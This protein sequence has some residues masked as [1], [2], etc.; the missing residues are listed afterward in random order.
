VATIAGQPA[1]GTLKMN[2]LKYRIAITIFILEAMM[3]SIV[4]WYTL[5]YAVEKSKQHITVSEQVTMELVDE[6]ARTALLTEEYDIIQPYIEKLPRNPDILHAILVD[7]SNVIVASDRFSELGN[8]LPLLPNTDDTHWRTKTIKNPAGSLGKLA[9]EFSSNPLSQAYNQAKTLGV[10][11]AIIGMSIIAMVGTTFGTVLTKRLKKLDYAVEEVGK[12]NF[13]VSTGIKGRDELGRLGEAF[14]TMAKQIERDNKQM[15]DMNKELEKRVE[16]RTKALADANS[17]YES[18]AYSVSH[19]LRAPLR[20]INGFSQALKDDYYDLLDD[21]AKDYL[22]RIQNASVRMGDL[23]DALLE[24]SRI[25]R[26]KIDVKQVNLSKFA[27][28]II[29][30][31]SKDPN[32]RPVNWQI[33]PNVKAYGDSRLLY[34]VLSNLLNNAWKFTQKEPN[35]TIEFGL[36]KLNGEDL[37]YV[38]DNG[39]G[40]NEDYKEKLFAP[41]NRLHRDSEFEGSGIGLS[42]VQRI[43]HRHGGRIWGE[44]KTGEGATFYF[45]LPTRTPTQSHAA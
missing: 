32:C 38:K 6:I 31:L 30:E 26:A 1:T 34:N 44:G 14:D 24:L 23:I 7:D 17:E 42:T 9:M 43:I 25:N 36:K 22:T 39:A 16:H 2:S 29:Q 8:S 41:F 3:M 13:N 18:F 33:Q 21:N 35:A 20:S 28:S 27:S 12:G 45:T 19:D 10:V 4:L 11:I 15:A 37:Y 40:F 5:N